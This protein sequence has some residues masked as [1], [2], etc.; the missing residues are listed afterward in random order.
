[1]LWS[2]LSSLLSLVSCLLTNLCALN[3]T[4]QEN[5]YMYV[6]THKG[7]KK[8]KQEQNKKKKGKELILKKDVELHSL[9]Q[10]T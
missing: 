10:N 4:Q 1:M 5:S 8:Q 2:S 3:E 7:K 9:K 6:C